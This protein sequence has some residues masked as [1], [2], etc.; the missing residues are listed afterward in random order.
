MWFVHIQFLSALTF[1][2]DSLKQNANEQINKKKMPA[3]LI[4]VALPM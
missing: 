1:E 2:D 4:L 3:L